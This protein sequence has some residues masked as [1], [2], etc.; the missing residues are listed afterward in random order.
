MRDEVSGSKSTR[1]IQ[2]FSRW[3]RTYDDSWVQRFF[4][5]V[6]QTMLNVVANEASEPQ[7]ILDVGCG[8]GRLLRKAGARWPAARLIGA[9][10]A[11]GMVE[12]A[13]RTTPAAT[14]HIAMAESLPLP[15]ASVDI[16]L[17]SASFHHWSDQAAGLREIARVL[18]L[19]GHLCLADVTMPAWLAKILRHS[20]AKSP[21][22]LHWFFTQAGLHVE[23]QR[24]ILA[25]FVL[26]TLGV[27]IS[28]AE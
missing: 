8:T 5:R 6:H 28:R 4:D 2:R 21:T 1:D 12:V 27:K 22:A 26:V 18:R 23:T 13:R 17:S 25:R 19:D 11:E 15:D 16:V 7:S 9:D 10:P 14:F 3:A 20:K 24:P